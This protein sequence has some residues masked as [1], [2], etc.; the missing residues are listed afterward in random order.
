MS[1]QIAQF[2]D[3]MVSL[4]S[5]PR[6]MMKQWA[7]FARCCADSSQGASVPPATIAADSAVDSTV[8]GL[9]QG[10]ISLHMPGIDLVTALTSPAPCTCGQGQCRQMICPRETQG[11]ES[12]QP[13]LRYG[14]ET[15]V[16]RGIKIAGMGKPQNW[17][18]GKNL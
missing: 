9:I 18:L 15:A 13:A 16:L 3:P 17:V 6:L 8:T 1:N 7:R 11:S 5:A 12:F 4:G 10:Y 14:R 2:L